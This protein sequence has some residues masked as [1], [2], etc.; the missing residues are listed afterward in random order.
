M[1]EEANRAV[2]QQL[3]FEV[4]SQRAET[5]KPATASSCQWV[6]DE[7]PKPDQLILSDWLVSGTGVYFIAGNEGSGK[8][9]LMKYLFYEPKTMELLHKWAPP[10]TMPLATAAFFFWRNGTQLEKSVEGL[11]RSILYSVLS[12]QPRIIPSVLPSIYAKAY[13]SISAPKSTGSD[14]GIEKWE[15]DV[16]RKAFVRLI[17]QE[18]LPIKLFFLIDGIDEFQDNQVTE[19]VMIDLFTEITASKHAKAIISSRKLDDMETVRIEPN[20]KLHDANHSAI[21]TYVKDTVAKELQAYADKLPGNVSDQIAV[22]ANGSFLWASLTLRNISELLAQGH[23]F[24]EADKLMKGAMLPSTIHEL[25]DHMWTAIPP[26]HKRRAWEIVQ[27]VLAGISEFPQTADGEIRLVDLMLALGDPED[28]IRSKIVEWRESTIKQKCEETAPFHVDLAGLSRC[29]KGQGIRS[30][31]FTIHTCTDPVLSQVSARILHPQES[32]PFCPHLA[33]VKG[34]V[35]HLKILPME[36]IQ[37]CKRLLWSFVTR[38]LLSSKKVELASPSQP[39]HM[40]QCHQ[41]LEQLD[42]TMTHHRDQQRKKGNSNEETTLQDPYGL[43][44]SRDFGRQKKYLGSLS[45]A[46]FHPDHLH[47]RG[48]EDSFLSLCIRFGLKDYLQ[49]HIALNR[50]I[51]KSKKGRPLLDYALCPAP[52]APYDLVTSEIVQVLL[53]NGPGPNEKVQDRSWDGKMRKTTCWEHALIWQHRTYAI[54]GAKAISGTAAHA[55]EIAELRLDIV[56]LL[57]Q[58][59]ANVRTHIL[60]ST[61]EKITAKAAL[62]QSFGGWV[63]AENL[64]VVLELL[65]ARLARRGISWIF[66]R[67]QRPAIG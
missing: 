44:K 15:I 63:K 9:T 7:Q 33:H 37:D 2:L 26:L 38:A 4:M 35:Q 24:D 3:Q 6:W 29:R 66:K 12:Q 18:Q 10:A 43:Y 61:G 32:P 1:K 62:Q 27:I 57:I 47:T 39:Q 19:R 17:Q 58:S 8:S 60:V 54:N 45:W 11:L 40:V 5:I 14:Q 67:S 23:S 48:D 49:D 16:L 36:V 52:I 21:R 20:L 65:D 31:D 59:G 53:E 22:S 42:L 50:K 46:N 64:T 25:Y 56:K 51:L 55:K 13:S 41:L 34:A 28:T 30:S